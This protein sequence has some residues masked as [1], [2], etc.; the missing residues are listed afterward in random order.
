MAKTKAKKRLDSAIEAVIERLEK[1]EEFT[2]E[3]APEVCKEIVKKHQV[4]WE[5]YSIK[6]GIFVLLGLLGTLGSGIGFYFAN[7]QDSF[8]WQITTGVLC[9]TSFILLMSS[10]YDFIDSVLKLRELK[11]S[12]KVTI[13]NE[14]GK[15]LK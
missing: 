1:M 15:L 13:I 7:Q 8:C 10:L 3:Q 12:P 6:E 14:L 11:V 2:L 5:N 9:S 4:K